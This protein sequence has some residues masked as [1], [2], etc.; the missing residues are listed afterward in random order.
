MRKT[1][2]KR[3]F[4]PIIC[5]MH[6]R[7]RVIGPVRKNVLGFTLIEVMSVV[8]LIAIMSGVA[9]YTINTNLDRIRADNGVRRIALALNYARIRAIAEDTNYLVSFHVRPTTGTDESKCYILMFGD[10]NKNGTL[11]TGEKSRTEDL[12]KGIVYDLNGPKDIYNLPATSNEDKDGVIF[13]NN[14]VTL[15][16]R[17]IAS[18]RG[19]IYIIPFNNLEDS[20]DNNR[21]A[22]SLEALSGKPIVWNYD[23]GLFGLGQNP[24]REEGK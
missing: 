9:V 1:Y 20:V 18:D 8:A 10:A 6:M 2:E 22:V 11:D 12:P 5:F 14:K 19:E 17:G 7:A 23:V 3:V 4:S 13:P 16:P 24:W 21:R 15:S